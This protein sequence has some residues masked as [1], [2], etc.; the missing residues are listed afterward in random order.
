M[1][2]ILTGATGFAGGEALRQALAAPDITQVTVLTRRSVSFVHPKLR[3]VLMRNFLDY[4]A[5]IWP[6][7]RAASGAS[8][9][10]RQA[11]QRRRAP[12]LRH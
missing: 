10:D 3:E 1:K 5:W 9:H 4:A 7:T 6:A 2:F 8:A 12:G 11:P